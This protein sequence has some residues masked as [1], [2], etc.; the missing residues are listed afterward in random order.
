MRLDESGVQEHVELTQLLIRLI[1]ECSWGEAGYV[2]AILQTDTAEMGLTPQGQDWPQPGQELQLGRCADGAS[3]RWYV[4]GSEEVP[5]PELSAEDLVEPTTSEDALRL[6]ELHRRIAE[7]E[8]RV[9]RQRAL[10]DRLVTQRSSAQAAIAQDLLVT[11]KHSVRH[12]RHN[13][14][15]QKGWVLAQARAS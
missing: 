8:R 4:D 5:L 15:L 3:L 7:G 6:E 13:L 1:D 12:L 10:V 14:E 11:L 2:R 9:E